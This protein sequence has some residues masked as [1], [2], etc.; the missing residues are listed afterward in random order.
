MIKLLPY[1]LFEGYVQ[2][3]ALEMASP[4]NQHCADFNG[5]VLVPYSRRDISKQVCVFSYLRMLK[6]WHCPHPLLCIMLQHRDVQQSRRAHSSK[7]AAV[8]EWDR[9]TDIQ[10]DGWTLYPST[11]PALH[12]MLAAIITQRSVFTYF[13][14][15]LHVI[16]VTLE[17]NMIFLVFAKPSVL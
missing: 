11:D 1:V 4:G 2:I 16:S 10:R 15:P 8:G 3:L 12:T 5:T 7:P 13:P 6:T 14:R 17:T 9:Q